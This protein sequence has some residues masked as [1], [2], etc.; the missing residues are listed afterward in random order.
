MRAAILND[1]GPKIEHE[2]LLRIKSYVGK[3]PPFPPER[4]DR[5]DEDDRRVE[6]PACAKE[7]EI[8]ARQTFVEKD[9]KVRC[10]TIRS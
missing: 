3:L 4:S 7:W 5:L 6:F 2:G 10:V 8:Y 1:I 9:G